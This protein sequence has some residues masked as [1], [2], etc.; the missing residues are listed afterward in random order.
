MSPQNVTPQQS[1][2][3]QSKQATQSAKQM[4]DAPASDLAFDV[5]RA[6]DMPH[7]PPDD[8]MRLQRSIGNRAV[9]NLVQ[10][11]ASQQRVQPKLKVGPA[12]DSYEREADQMAKRVMR[13]Q[14]P[15]TPQ[16]K[17]DE[18]AQRQMGQSQ[19][20][21]S[22]QRATGEGSQRDAK[23]SAEG[24]TADQNFTRQLNASKT[25]GNPLGNNTRS[26]MESR[27]NADFGGVRI[28]TGNQ[29][30]QLNHDIQAKAFT[31][32]N[33]I[34]F[35][36]GAYSPNTG[37]GKELLAHELTHVVQQGAAVQ[38][39]PEEHPAGES[40]SHAKL[41]TVQRKSGVV[42][43]RGFG[44]WIKSKFSKKKDET[45]STPPPTT[46]TS[47]P[48]TTTT[49]T[50]KPQPD[51]TLQDSVEFERKLGRLAYNHS[52][53]ANAAKVMTDK[54]TTAMVGDLEEDNDKQQRE[55][56]A[57]YG[58]DRVNS[59]GQVGANLKAVMGVLKEGNLRERLTALMNA[60]FGPFK[61]YI[62][63][64]M[65]ESAWD[66]MGKKG[67]NVE[68]LKRRKRQMKFNLGAK[69]LYRDPGNPLDRKNFSSY[70]MTG[71]TRSASPEDQRGSKRTVGDLGGD[72]SVGLSE[73]EKELQFPGK[74]D[75]E[76]QGENLKWQE[77]GTYWAVNKKNKWVKNI[78]NS[79]HMPVVA[80][81][82]GSMLRMFQLWEYL[83]KPVSA[84]DWRLAVLGWMLS[85][86]DHSFH[87]MMMTAA[88]FG[89]SY[90]P[91]LQAYMDVAPLSVAELREYAAEDGLFPHERAL[92]RKVKGKGI[93][94]MMEKSDLKSGKSK[95]KS[96]AKSSKESSLSGTGAA[97]IDLYTAFGYLVL[98]PTRSGS[99]F[100]KMQVT[101]NAKTKDEM[102]HFKN[103]FESGKLTAQDLMQEANEIIPVLD[104]ALETLP[105]WKGELFR[106]TGTFSPFS[107]RKGSTISFSNYTSSTLDEDTAKDFADNFNKGP[108]KYILHL[109]TTAGKD[110]RDLSANSGEDEIL[111]PA[112]SVFEVTRRVPPKTGRAYYHVYMKQTARG[113]RALKLQP[114]DDSTVDLGS[115][116]LPTSSG[117][118]SGGSVKVLQE[119]TLKMP[120]MACDETGKVLMNIPSGETIGATGVK[121]DDLVE[122]A[123]NDTKYW[124]T[125]K[126]W[127]LAVREA[128]PEGGGS[129][130]T[131]TVVKPDTLDI[132]D[133][134]DVLQ[135]KLTDPGDINMDDVGEY[136]SDSGVEWVEISTIAGQLYWVKKAE[137]FAF[138]GKEYKPKV[139]A[140]SSSGG[141]VSGGSVAP[142]SSTPVVDDSTPSSDPVGVKAKEK[143]DQLILY[144]GND[145]QMGTLENESEII[146]D[147][148]S[149]T[150]DDLGVEWQEIA[151]TSGLFWTK[152][153]ELFAFL[154]LPYVS[155]VKKKPTADP[156]VGSIK[157]MET[158]VP[159]VEVSTISGPKTQEI[160]SEE[161]ES[162]G[163]TDEFEEIP[164]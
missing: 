26:F 107:Y 131:P 39:S 6:V 146:D 79:L 10:Q 133:S 162:S 113:G 17:K 83:S 106:G 136:T 111:I 123:Y 34:Y 75:D 3:Q 161:V 9:S 108:F 110:V 102:D 33:N 7:I 154:G 27:F 42:I 85:S 30:A 58:R 54:M 163:K 32:G 37:S 80:G 128:Y 52:K 135:G 92:E 159:K 24:F 41:T 97:A 46:T 109:D 139:V 67:L 35:N 13:M 51:E 73:R 38:R 61:E 103:D 18:A 57:L 90:T 25:G 63:K 115:S 53:S 155:K 45:E 158:V 12:D 4:Q 21:Q 125:P 82:S 96:F 122:F 112:G 22:I 5:Q 29:A 120:A 65:R 147:D 16:R 60:M 40:A 1:K 127:S 31:H 89:L 137:L 140:G 23:S 43:Q 91:G 20:G 116:A 69:D 153:E 50:D 151:T 72:L 84:A 149:Y 76:I 28:H 2:T 160:E 15:I 87:E 49:D 100:A 62:L 8:V 150:V 118:S 138:Q 93:K 119:Y 129:D 101:R 70:V 143:L 94:H 148:S 142:P 71:R 164:L 88:D 95:A 55:L 11:R 47:S 19:P 77:G 64:A 152:R 124:M 117:S 81:P 132:Y 157:M 59:A 99:R 141:D 66:E 48:P 14:A 114:D 56:V 68:K 121:K 145:I 144:D 78:E 74:K 134:N 44:S 156:S 98:N 104:S 36:K 86:N 105:D 130:A 126:W